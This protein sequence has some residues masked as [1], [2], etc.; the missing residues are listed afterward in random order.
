MKQNVGIIDRIIRVVIAIGLFYAAMKWPMASALRITLSVIGG[1]TLVTS[2]T[3]FCGIYKLL[4]IS[5]SKARPISDESKKLDDSSD[6]QEPLFK[7]Q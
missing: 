4:G 7:G 3:G 1:L 2:V 5:T 6:T